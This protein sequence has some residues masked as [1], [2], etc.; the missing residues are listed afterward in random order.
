MKILLIGPY[1]PP[2]GGISVH[3]YELRRRLH[4]AGIDCRVVNIDPRALDSP[5]YLCVRG[6]TSL[7]RTLVQY[8][9]RAWT[10]HV[11]IN[12]H[13]HKSWLI[14]LAAGIAGVFGPGNVLTLHSGLIPDYLAPGRSAAR[15]LSRITC[16]L[17]Q[18]IIAVG[19]EVRDALLSLDLPD[20]R[21]AVLPA[22][23]YAQPDKNGGIELP[24]WK[25]RRPL[26]STALCFR[27]E[28]G[29]NVL[30]EAIDQLRGRYPD[31]LCLVMGSGEEHLQA[32]RLIAERGL[33]KWI[34][35]LGNVD[36][37]KCLSL[38]GRADIFVRTT[39]GDGDANSVR[40]ALQLGRRVVASNVGHRP[41]GVDLFRAGDAG[42]LAAKLEQA[43]LRPNPT[44]LPA[45]APDRDGVESLIEMYESLNG[46]RSQ[47]EYGKTQS[48]AQHAHQ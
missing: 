18:R 22:F 33:G 2:H 43:W 40:E 14:A 36:H 39:F 10:L 31:L 44:A 30:V 17:Y 12:G 38:I 8:A 35:L 23:I 32:Q 9:R 34:V 15:S 11:H 25:D 20:S 37:G 28:Y 13:N 46:S 45:R 3:V 24:S 16:S 26:I 27:P 5:E 42:D 47:K 19:P 4:M 6:G 48:L 7:L 21:I 1:P 41:P 29:F